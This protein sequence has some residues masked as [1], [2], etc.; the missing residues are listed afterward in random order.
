[1]N[2]RNA[3]AL[4][5]APGLALILRPANA[6]IQGSDPD[7]VSW[8]HQSMIAAGLGKFLADPVKRA[9]AVQPNQP[10]Y[11]T[12]WGGFVGQPGTPLIAYP[13]FPETP[14][15]TNYTLG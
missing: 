8:Q 13:R 10:G 3:I 14:P 15:G 7:L 11:V 12:V 4:A 1:M 5:A 6:I 2:R 9:F